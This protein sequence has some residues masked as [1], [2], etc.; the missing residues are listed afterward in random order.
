MYDCQLYSGELAF[1]TG[2]LMV[3]GEVEWRRCA[4][5][6]GSKCGP[7]AELRNPANVHGRAEILHYA[8][9]CQAPLN[10][11]LFVNS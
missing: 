7:A 9:A 4:V 8:V 3:D 5:V 10:I 1:R 11:H 2:G 6:A